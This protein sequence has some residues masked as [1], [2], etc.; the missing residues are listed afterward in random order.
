MKPDGALMC[1]RFKTH[2][3]RWAYFTLWQTYVRELQPRMSADCDTVE[4]DAGAG[5]SSRTIHRRMQRCAEAYTFQRWPTHPLRPPDKTPQERAKL[6]ETTPLFAN[7]HSEAASAGQTAVPDISADVD[8]HFTCFVEAPSPPAREDQIEA[9]GEGR[10]LVELDG[11]RGGPVDRGVCTDLLADAAA[12]IR[13]HFVK[14][15][16]SVS[17]SMLA[18]APPAEF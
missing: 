5:K 3:G 18:L 15:A 14:D 4:R 17:F 2:V 13:D 16:T 10:R 9:E 1:N 12:Y 7:I 8:L 6:L 11:R